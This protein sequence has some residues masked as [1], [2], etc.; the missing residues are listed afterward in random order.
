M[1]QYIGYFWEN[2]PNYGMYINI[3]AIFLMQAIQFIKS[4]KI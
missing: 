3:K 4:D 1:I 2:F